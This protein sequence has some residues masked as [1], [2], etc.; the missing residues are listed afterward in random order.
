MESITE[1]RVEFLEPKLFL[2]KITTCLDRAAV[3]LIFLRWMYVWSRRGLGGLCSV[4]GV[5]RCFWNLPLV[6]C[7]PWQTSL[8]NFCC[9][10]ESRLLTHFIRQF[11]HDKVSCYT[12]NRIFVILA[13]ASYYSED[14]RCL[15]RI[16]VDV[17]WEA[18]V[19]WSDGEI[20]SPS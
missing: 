11:P 13:T 10:C 3:C 6:T 9:L 4:Q 14:F 12:L 5:K 2:I 7:L 20:I 19:L 8:T 15:G 18:S 16:V 17:F 1:L